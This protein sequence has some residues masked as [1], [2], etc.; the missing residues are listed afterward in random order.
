MLPALLSGAALLF[1]L[2]YIGL[3]ARERKF[4]QILLVSVILFL[5]KLPIEWNGFSEDFD[6]LMRVR[7]MV[8][9]FAVSVVSAILSYGL[10][11]IFAKVFQARAKVV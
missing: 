11:Y 4:L 1:S 8:S 2:T 6:F 7:I 10:V 5:M 3:H 9:T